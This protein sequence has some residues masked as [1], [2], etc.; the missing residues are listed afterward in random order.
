MTGQRAAKNGQT[1]G[2]VAINA[3]VV[4]NPFGLVRIAAAPVERSQGT[5]AVPSLGSAMRLCRKKLRRRLGR[6]QDFTVY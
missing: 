3:L 1:L 4:R 2:L 6:G 5:G